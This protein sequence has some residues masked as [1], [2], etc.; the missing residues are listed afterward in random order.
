MST[1]TNR[2]RTVGSD[3]AAT[4]F[5]FSR[6]AEANGSSALA[7]VGM[8]HALIDDWREMQHETQRFMQHRFEENV[9]RSRKLAGCRGAAEAW[10]VNAGFV[11]KM[12][13]DYAE[14]TGRMAEL[15]CEMGTACSRFGAD[16]VHVVEEAGETGAGNG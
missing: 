2:A 14:A 6:L 4:A 5:P 7:F 15:A 11:Q 9:D 8:T 13:A 12:A 10:S 1:H 3:N 16:I